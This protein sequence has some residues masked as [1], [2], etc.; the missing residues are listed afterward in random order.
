M[1]KTPDKGE[2]FHVIHQNKITRENTLIN[3]R[4]KVD[5]TFGFPMSHRV[6]KI[7]TLKGNMVLFMQLP[8]A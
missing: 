2:I 4:A 7:L 1:I 5:Y 6:C 3:S 8:Q